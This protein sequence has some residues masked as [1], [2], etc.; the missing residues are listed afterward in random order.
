[1][2]EAIVWTPTDL[3]TGLAL[4]FVPDPN[5][6][7][8]PR[9]SGEVPPEVADVNHANHPRLDPLLAADIDSIT[10]SAGPATRECR[11][12]FVLR[13][14]HE[15]YHREFYGPHLP[16][17]TVGRFFMCAL[18]ASGYVP[19]EALDFS[20]PAT[21]IVT[22]THMQ[23]ERLRTSGE[24]K[25]VSGEIVRRFLLEFAFSQGGENIKPATINEL[26]LLSLN[27]KNPAKQARLAE[28]LLDGLVE[29]AIA[30]QLRDTYRYGKKN[31]LIRPGLPRSVLTFVRQELAGGEQVT[32]QAVGRI[33]KQCVAFKF[34][35]GLAAA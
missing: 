5:L 34:S 33:V 29:P 4:P 30:G 31:S 11:G 13:P 26:I 12:Q 21:R 1:M 28:L 22:L 15:R 18:A 16:T 7:P 27:K 20:R 23:R 3:L 6:P 10:P 2:A 14:T 8:V 25:M 9:H 24:I 17:T 19:P 35:G 32:R